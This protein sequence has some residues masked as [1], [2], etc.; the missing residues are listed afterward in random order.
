MIVFLITTIEL[1]IDK[2]LELQSITIGKQQ[3]ICEKVWGSLRIRES[4]GVAS[5]SANAREFSYL[6]Q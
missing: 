1:K 5:L 6:R 2:Y 4:V 3:D